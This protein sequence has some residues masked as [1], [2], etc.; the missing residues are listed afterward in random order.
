MELNDK[1]QNKYK[2]IEKVVNNEISKKDAEIELKLSRKQINRLIS[3]FYEQGKEGFIHKNRGKSNSNK[4]ASNIINEIKELYIKEYYDYNLEA[5]FEVIEGKYNISYST[6]YNEFLKDD[7]VSPIAHKK[8]MKL[9]NEK[10]QKAIATIDENGQT[11]NFLDDKVELFKTRKL[12]QE[13]AYIR[14]SSNLLAF[15]Q[16]VQLDACSKLWFGNIVSFLHL[17]VDKATKKVLFGWFEYEELTRGYFVVLFHILL[18]YGIPYKIK[19]DNRSSFSTN[20]KDKNKFNI[21][22]FGRICEYLGILLETTSNA[23]SKANVERE[24]GTFKNRLIAELR[25][26]NITEIDSANEYLNKI[27]IPKMNK[28]FSY[29][30]NEKTSMMKKNDYTYD[31]LNLII[32]ERYTRIID[33]ASSI[34][35][36]GKYYIPVD[37]DTGEI[38]TYKHRTECTV[39]I[40]YDSSYWCEIENNYYHLCEI[41]KREKVV[42]P[43]KKETPINSSKTKYIPPANHPWRKDMKKFFQ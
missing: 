31:D 36:Y 23:V 17:A 26:E 14:R 43:E 4:K 40:A 20:K 8:T 25:H 10:M 34:S 5:F 29:D 21:T 12:E 2:I 24:N 38:M 27:F 28:K 1:E 39:I 30:I 22:Q 32:S 6:M 11:N 19:T 7:I 41:S 33:N 13:K 16:E 37:D 42:E 18:N 3:V 35:F 9:Y 15:G